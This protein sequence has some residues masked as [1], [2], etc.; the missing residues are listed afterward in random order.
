MTFIQFPAKHVYKLVEDQI[1]IA[2]ANLGFHYGNARRANSP[3][4][5]ALIQKS[6]AL[7]QEIELP[8]AP[9]MFA[10]RLKADALAPT[11]TSILR[12]RPTAH[13]RNPAGHHDDGKK[14]HTAA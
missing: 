3:T 8:G 13:G 10:L 4:R 2:A 9:S 14:T 11:R 1:L 5:E 7:L 6:E 12:D